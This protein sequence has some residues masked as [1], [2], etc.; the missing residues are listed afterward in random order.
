MLVVIAF[1]TNR[2]NCARSPSN[3]S[4]CVIGRARLSSTGRTAIHPPRSPSQHRAPGDIRARLVQHGIRVVDM[5]IDF[6]WTAHP[7]NLFRLPFADDT[8][9]WPIWRAVWPL[10][11]NAD[12][13]VI[14]P[15][16]AVEKQDVRGLN[17]LQQRVIDLRDCRHIGKTLAGGA[18]IIRPERGFFRRELRLA[19]A[20]TYAGKCVAE[21][22]RAA[23][24]S[25]VLASRS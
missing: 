12:Q 22:K 13:F 1:L 4:K 14:A 15:E 5:Q 18:S 25:G 6:T 19:C 11:L 10:A 20:E 9:T 7:A 23:K 8:G 2:A 24:Q 17:F 16:S 3:E 21:R